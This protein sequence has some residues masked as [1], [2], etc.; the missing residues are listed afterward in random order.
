MAN[1]FFPMKK[2]NKMVVVG[3]LV[4]WV[5]WGLSAVLLGRTNNFIIAEVIFMIVAPI[6]AVIITKIEFAGKGGQKS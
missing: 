6:L 5:L 1:Q 4:F 3:C 2:L